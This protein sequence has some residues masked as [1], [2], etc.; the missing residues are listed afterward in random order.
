MD[1]LNKEIEN[2]LNENKDLFLSFMPSKKMFSTD[3]YGTFEGNGYEDI[4]PN[5]YFQSSQWDE[6][7]K[8]SYINATGS[9]SDTIKEF[10]YLIEDHLDRELEFFGQQ[11]FADNIVDGVSSN[12]KGESITI[13][14]IYKK[15]QLN[16]YKKYE[17]EIEFE[18]F[19]QE[20]K[21][22]LGALVGNN[23]QSRTVD[24]Y[25]D[26][27]VYFTMSPLDK[28]DFVESSMMCYSRDHSALLMSEEVIEVL[29]L[30]NLSQDDFNNHYIRCGL[31]LDL[32]SI[33]KHL[34][35]DEFWS[36]EHLQKECSDIPKIKID[37]LMSSI[38]DNKSSIPCIL[39]R[40]NIMEL[41]NEQ[42]SKDRKQNKINIKDGIFCLSNDDNTTFF[43]KISIDKKVRI[44]EVQ[45]SGL[46]VKEV[47]MRILKEVF[48]TNYPKEKNINKISLSK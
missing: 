13:K 23:D 14:D 6:F 34:V 17:E 19:D 25:K 43:G 18:D 44:N 2:Y 24:L 48:D 29:E 3:T 42:G 35:E 41:V 38:R 12:N 15:F 20:F 22:Q 39:I 47:P 5:E 21:E 1:N 33:D 9:K 37:H 28:P 30:L 8:Q 11:S 27:D 46:S 40:K 4:N 26:R 16:F 31:D 45:E 36:Y 32:K 7:L 10:E